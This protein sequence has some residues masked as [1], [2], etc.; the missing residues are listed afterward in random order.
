[1]LV[2]I[3]G[4]FLCQ[5]LY[6]FLSALVMP[7]VFLFLFLL[8]L[9]LEHQ[10]LCY[11][12][13]IFC[14]AYFRYLAY[15]VRIFGCLKNQLKRTIYLFN[16]CSLQFMRILSPGEPKKF[17]LISGLLVS[18]AAPEGSSAAFPIEGWVLKLWFT[19]IN[20]DKC[21]MF[22]CIY[23]HLEHSRQGKACPLVTT[24]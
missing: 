22:C 17:Q 8:W 24:C 10:W 12:I 9:R 21:S 13:W 3:A 19:I 14:V 23:S 1:M 5:S 7:S 20:I 16:L 6:R 4:V 2:T 11:K 18:P 15:V